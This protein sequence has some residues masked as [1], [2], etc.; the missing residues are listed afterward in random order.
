MRLDEWIDE[1]GGIAHRD[2]ADEA[3]F[4]LAARRAAVR[5]RSVER[6]RRNWLATAAAPADLRSAAANS[7]RLA[8]IS[9]ARRRGWWIPERIDAKVHVR[10]D[11]NGSSPDDDVVAHWSRQL[12]PPSQWGLVESIEDA[13]AHIATCLT[14]VDAR[15]VWESAIR[16]EGLSIDALRRVHWPTVAASACADA[17]TGLS[18]SGLETICVVK[19]RPW[20]IPIRQQI[21]IAGRR[22]DLLIGE[23]LVVQIDGF[24][25]HSTSAQRTKDVAL[26]A[27]LVLRGYTV[28]RFTY[29]QVLHDW[30]A[31]ER[32]IARAI[33]TGAHRA[34]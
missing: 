12:A 17:V 10:L 4:S 34:A 11:P 25:H 5:E 21:V 1:N 8:C 31:V 24:A 3:G 16:T 9:V 14:P 7:G 29:A 19:L 27:E 18:D 22:V 2:A 23:R 13:L 20:G 30:D 26:D 33:A 32:A 6:I 15:V 28:L